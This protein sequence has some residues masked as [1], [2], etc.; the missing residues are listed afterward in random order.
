MLAFYLSLVETEEE[1]DQIEKVYSLYLDC[2]LRYA[3]GYLQNMEDAEDAVN[4]AFLN[5]IKSKASIPF[6]SEKRTKSYLFI[7]VRNCASKIQKKNNRTITV[8]LEEQ[9]NLPSSEA[10]ESGIVDK[11]YKEGFVAF[12]NTL[13][14]I[15]KDILSLYFVFEKSLKEIS[16]LLNVPL[17]TVETRFKRGKDLLKKYVGDIN[18]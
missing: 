5:I 18:D 3:F 11:E 2:M 10:V 12:L 15:Y 7:C 13:P 16:Y 6:D 17:K 14:E 9:C 4:D 1:K 8:N